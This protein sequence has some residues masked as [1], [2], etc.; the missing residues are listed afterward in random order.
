MKLINLP[1]ISPHRRRLV[2]GLGIVAAA[3]LF[4]WGIGWFAPD[5]PI[6][7]LFLTEGV[8]RYQSLDCA[9][10]LGE[11]G[12]KAKSAI[13]TLLAATRENDWIAQNAAIA[14]WRIDRATN[15]LVEVFS[16]RM[17]NVP[18]IRQRYD[19]FHDFAQL[20]KDLKPADSIVVD[21]VLFNSTDSQLGFYAENYL[22][23]FDPQR[24][25]EVQDSLNENA[26]ALLPRHIAALESTNMWA[27]RHAVHAIWFYGPAAADAVPVLIK[28]LRQSELNKNRDGDMYLILRVLEEI[29]PQAVAVTP[30]LAALMRTVV[31]AQQRELQTRP[32]PRNLEPRLAPEALLFLAA[33]GSIGPGASN[34]IPTIEFC[35]TNSF[36]PEAHLDAAVA[37][38]Q[39]DPNNKI[40]IAELKRL[41]TNGDPGLLDRA[42]SN[43]STINP[44]EY[45][46][47]NSRQSRLQMQIRARVALWRLGL[48]RELPLPALMAEAAHDGMWAIDLLG[49]IGPPAREALPVLEHYITELSGPRNLATIAILKIDPAEAKRL[50]LPGWLIACPDTY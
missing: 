37:L 48:E 42:D 8:R 40:A 4:A 21:R 9:D 11:I 2:L 28:R 29:G 33:L 1:K 35:L 46:Y 32:R 26:A 47:S 16:N 7:I 50:G 22:K 39:I 6:R 45:L 25:R 24:L 17:V 15:V 36:T 34:A 14:L 31:E 12:P 27:R 18:D 10:Q 13:P 49:E 41:Q 3:V 5:S 43:P 38:S 23:Q 20:G 44:R 30:N 19:I